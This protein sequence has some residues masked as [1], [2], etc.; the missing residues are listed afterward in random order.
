MPCFIFFFQAEDGI[1]DKLVTGVQTCALPISLRW[2]HT[3]T[4][5]VGA[6]L[7]HLA[8]TSIVLTNSASVHADP[9]ADWTIAA[10]AY[11]ARGLDRSVAF[12]AV[13][14][15]ATGELTEVPVQV[16]GVAGLRLGGF[17]VGGVGGA[18][19]RR[20]GAVGVGVAG[21]GAGGA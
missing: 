19:A 18:V 17:G 5:G 4:A 21:G 11:F 8:G 13:E 2:A 20:G 3:A 6:S 1:R 16:R 9:I 14:H 7:A 10:L 12:Q 15:W